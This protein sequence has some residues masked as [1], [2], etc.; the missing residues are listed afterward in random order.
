MI[1]DEADEVIKEVFDSLKYRCQNNFESMKGSVF[2]LDYVQL[3]YYRC[4]KINPTR[5]GSYINFSD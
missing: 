3:L 2:V 5:E 4:K 1:N